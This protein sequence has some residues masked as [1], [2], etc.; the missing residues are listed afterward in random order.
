[1]GVHYIGVETAI[2][3]FTLRHLGDIMNCYGRRQIIVEERENYHIRL[4]SVS[5]DTQGRYRYQ[6]R[7]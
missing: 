4:V 1:M 5:A 6:S 7:P 3:Q 2:L